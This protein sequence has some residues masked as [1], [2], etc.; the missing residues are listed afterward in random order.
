MEVVMYVS[1]DDISPTVAGLRHHMRRYA[2][3]AVKAEHIDDRNP[4]NFFHSLSFQKEQTS[5]VPLIE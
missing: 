5:W 4:D 1:S 3:A 2:Q